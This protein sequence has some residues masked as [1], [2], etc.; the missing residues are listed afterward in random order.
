VPDV[1]Y[2]TADNVALKMDIQ[3]PKQ[4]TG[5]TLPV[6]VNIHGGSWSA[7]D[8]TRSDSAADIPELVGRG[9]VVVSVNYRLAPKY[10]F[11]AQIQ[12][13]KCAIRF[14]RTNA[15]R[16]DIDPKRIGAWGCSAGGHLAALLGVTD[17]SNGFDGTTQYLDQS[18]RVQAVALLSTPT[19]ITLYDPV[20]RADM[21]LRVFGATTG[22]NPQLVKASPTSYISSDDAPFLI[23]QGDKDNTVS[24]LNGKRLY[25]KL[26][27]VGVPA[28]LVTVKNGQHCLPSDPSL[29]PSREEITKKIGDFFDRYLH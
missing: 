22:T 5:A 17:P 1:V 14:L 28:E 10:K 3:Y 21:L 7:G 11:P 18:S 23:V 9:Y 6:A 12:D 25:D 24:P 13:V 27:A 16:L 2:C 29:S 8:K 4:S 15:A 20:A 26:A 19:D